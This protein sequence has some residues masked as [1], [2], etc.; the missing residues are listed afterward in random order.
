MNGYQFVNE[1]LGY[2]KD[3]IES[4]RSEL[5]SNGAIRKALSRIDAMGIRE[6]WITSNNGEQFM[7]DLDL[8]SE[9]GQKLLNERKEK[10]KMAALNLTSTKK[11]KGNGKG[12]AVLNLSGKK[13]EEK[14]NSIDALN[15][16]KFA[17]VRELK[18]KIEGMEKANSL[19]IAYH[20]GEVSEIKAMIGNM[21]KQLNSMASSIAHFISEQ[22]KVKADTPKE[23][24]ANN[25]KASNTPKAIGNGNSIYQAFHK[26]YGKELKTNDELK[27]S[28]QVFNQLMKGI[29]FTS[30]DT[31][32]K[33]LGKSHYAMRG[34]GYMPYALVSS[35]KVAQALWN[36]YT[37]NGGKADTTKAPGKV[38]NAKYFANELGIDETDISPIFQQIRENGEYT[39]ENQTQ[40]NDYLMELDAFD[41]NDNPII[42]E[43]HQYLTSL[44]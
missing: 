5:I 41:G 11:G 20:K 24:K 2:D 36:A 27:T 7:M 44:V 16:E 8:P 38:L 34:D 10:I 29:D 31:F 32:I 43:L 42:I 26:A 23:T 9:F 37:S 22:K 12:K 28:E 17:M 13:K 6:Y 21:E 4:F 19:S 33:S 3:S 39:K 1:L 15:I 35:K 30:Y 14:S 25:T 18:E 40:V